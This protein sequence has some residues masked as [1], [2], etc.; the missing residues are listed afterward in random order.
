MI[1]HACCADCSYK[2]VQSLAKNYER[3]QLT[4]FYYNPN[5][6]PRSEYLARLHALKKISQE[7]K[8]KLIIPNHQPKLY[9]QAINTINPLTEKSR[10][11]HACWQLRITKTCQYAQKN[12]INQF[13]TTLLSSQYQNT[14]II[15]NIAINVAKKYNLKF[16]QPT[17]I[18]QTCQTGFYKQ[19]YCGCSFSLIEKHNQKYSLD[20]L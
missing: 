9:F 12:N 18:K 16:F 4:L 19:N 13:T 5:I 8:V 10:R 6:H 3:S 14:R 11:C 1:I 7:L 20:I 15:S 2:L 17:N